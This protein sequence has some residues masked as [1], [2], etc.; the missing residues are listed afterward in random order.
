MVAV[1]DAG[2]WWK[3][4][5]EAE[6]VP[7]VEWWLLLLLLLTGGGEWPEFDDGDNEIDAAASVALIRLV[8]AVKRLVGDDRDSFTDDDDD[9]DEED[10]MLLL[11]LLLLLSAWCSTRDPARINKLERSV[12]ELPVVGCGEADDEVGDTCIMI[13]NDK[14]KEDGGREGST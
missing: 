3:K 7:K 2:W 11:V 9:D 12:S 4:E 13:I 6:A 8:G 1:G 5:E 14:N 10:V